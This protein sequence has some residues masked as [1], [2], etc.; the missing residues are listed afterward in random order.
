METVKYGDFEIA[1]DIQKTKEYYSDLN[2]EET[3]SARNFRKYC[4]N[5]PDEEKFFSKALA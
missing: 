2:A 5:M 4:E 3:Q 1:T